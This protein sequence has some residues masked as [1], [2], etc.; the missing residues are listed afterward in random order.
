V[1][2]VLSWHSLECLLLKDLDLSCLLS[3]EEMA[4]KSGDHI[5]CDSEDEVREIVQQFCTKP[6]CGAH[7]TQARSCLAWLEESDNFLRQIRAAHLLLVFL[8]W[9]WVQRS[10]MESEDNSPLGRLRLT[11]YDLWKKHTVHVELDANDFFDGLLPGKTVCKLTLTPWANRF[12]DRYE[13]HTY[14]IQV[15]ASWSGF[16]SAQLQI[17]AWYVRAILKSSLGLDGFYLDPVVAAGSNIAGHVLGVGRRCRIRKQQIDDWVENKLEA[18]PICD[19]ESEH[20]AIAARITGYLRPRY[21]L[22]DGL[23]KRVERAL[24]PFAI[25]S[26]LANVPSLPPLPPKVSSSSSVS[27]PRPEQFHKLAMM[28]NGLYPF[29]D[30]AFVCPDESQTILTIGCNRE[31]VLHNRFLL[32]VASSTD[33]LLPFRNSADSRMR[34]LKPGGPFSPENVRT[35]EGFFSALVYRGITHNTLFLQENKTLFTSLDDWYD[36]CQPHHVSGQKQGYFCNRSAYG[37]TPIRDRTVENVVAYW[38]EAQDFEWLTNEDKIDPWDL[39]MRFKKIFGFGPLISYL[40]VVDYAECGMTKPL[41]MAHVT[42]F[43]CDIDKGGM[44]GLTTL[45]YDVDKKSPAKVTKALQ[46]LQTALNTV[47]PWDKR[48]AMDFGLVF[49]E[50]ALCKLLRLDFAEFKEWKD[51]ATKTTL[52]Y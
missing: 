15:L 34:I 36:T 43:I 4:R 6:V 19:P 8:V 1:K 2:A 23:V 11:L 41:T 21:G 50:H 35:K 30:P 9:D 38:K 51:C 12:P 20:S 45:G 13:F 14:A 17:K 7:I 47:I 42:S 18:H 44:R 46:S 26:N 27:V 29:L 40:L 37:K 16:D 28:I 31:Q 25:P 3:L 49:M 5:V 10:V 32:H 24:A 52:S 39:Y 22:D 48:K 33:K